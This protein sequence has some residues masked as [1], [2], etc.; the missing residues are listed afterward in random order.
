[1]GDCEVSGWAP[2]ACTADCGFAGI[3]NITRKIVYKSA[4]MA[5]CPPL[6]LTR[7]CNQRRCPKDGAVDRW[8]LWSACS[9]PCGGGSRTR[10]REILERAE[11]GGL[12]NPESLQVEV[13]NTHACDEDC[14]LAEWTAWS[15]CSTAYLS[16]HRARFRQV[17][18]PA[19]GMGKCPEEWEADRREAMTC[20]VTTCG[21]NAPKCA[22]KLD[23]VFVL[24]GSGSVG[25]G[26]FIK[27]GAFAKSLIERM[28]LVGET[29]VAAD[30]VKMRTT[31]SG[32][33]QK[34]GVVAFGGKA[35]V[36]ADLDKDR[37]GLEADLTAA[38]WTGDVHPGTNTPAALAL[39]R[40]L[41]E[42]ATVHVGANKVALVVT[43]GPPNSERETTT[44]VERLKAAGVRVVFITV[45]SG[46][47]R[48][49][50]IQWASWPEQ[51]NV[52]Q[53]TSFASLEEED[54]AT[55]VLVNICPVLDTSR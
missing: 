49:N 47:R 50:L 4:A 13:C 15:N 23:L 25:S 45:G 24:D 52:M 7:K 53:A 8:G 12:P 3:Q 33:L 55:K 10:R 2:T 26:D 22:A 48:R 5:Q 31:Q 20:N 29:E 38:A 36:I 30:S 9:R 42:R 51:E 43:D 37:A 39:T 41:F 28:H 14:W 35:S 27:V 6:Q 21:D 17:S 34:V 46:V 54:F 18:V 11:N 19:S 44:E 32:G 16:G 40:D 1:M